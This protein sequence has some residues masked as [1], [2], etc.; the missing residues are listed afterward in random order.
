MD[1]SGYLPAEVPSHWQVYFA[2]KDTD[3]T[4]YTGRI[5]RR[6]R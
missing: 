4:I 1:A 3:A 6:A 2:V 5:P